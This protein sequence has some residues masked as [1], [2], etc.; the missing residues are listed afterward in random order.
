MVSSKTLRVEE[1]WESLTDLTRSQGIK[2]VLAE[3]SLL[4]REKF[5]FSVSSSAAGSARALFWH[6]EACDSS[7]G[8]KSDSQSERGGSAIGVRMTSVSGRPLHLGKEF[9]SEL[10]QYVSL[11]ALRTCGTTIKGRQKGKLRKREID[12]WKVVWTGRVGYWKR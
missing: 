10:L 3:F 12:G 1:S 6:F 7:G 5:R 9:S 4:V 11:T 8:R 2:R